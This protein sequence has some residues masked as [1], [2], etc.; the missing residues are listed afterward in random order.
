MYTWGEIL[1]ALQLVDYMKGEHIVEELNL[2]AL[3]FLKQ[4]PVLVSELDLV[5]GR[6]DDLG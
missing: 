1:Q 4:S 6:V 5:E 2:E 3:M